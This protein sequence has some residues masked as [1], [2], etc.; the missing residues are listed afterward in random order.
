MTQK[1]IPSDFVLYTSQNS[2]NF[3]QID[4]SGLI[5]EGRVVEGRS[6]DRKPKSVMKFLLSRSPGGREKINFSP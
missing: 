4:L 1:S 2:N 6:T 5:K 3:R